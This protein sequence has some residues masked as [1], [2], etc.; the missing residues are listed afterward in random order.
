MS[1]SLDKL[2]QVC[3]R[4]RQLKTPE[5]GRFISIRHRYNQRRWLCF[6]CVPQERRVRRQR[7]PE[8]IRE[9]LESPAA[10]GERHHQIVRIAVALTAKRYSP[11]EIFDLLRPNY[12]A[13][14]CN[15]VPDEEIRDIIEFASGCDFSSDQTMHRAESLRLTPP[16]EAV[17]N[18][19]EFLHGTR[20]TEADLR[21]RCHFQLSG[22]LW[23][24]AVA[25]LALLFQRGE[26]VNLVWGYRVGADGKPQPGIGRTEARGW[27]MTQFYQRR[28]VF[29]GDAGAWIRMNPLDGEGIANRNVVKFRYTLVEFDKVPLDLQLSFLAK[30]DLPIAAIATSG[31]KSLHAW[32]HVGERTQ[33]GYQEKVAAIY[34]RLLPF[35]IDPAN[36]NP[37]RLAR[38]P[39]A[40]RIIGATG[41]GLQRLLFV[42]P[43]PSGQPIL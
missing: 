38:L 39:G 12:D 6:E 40:R 42:T 22:A 37:S 26:Q 28:A 24:H 17:R 32:V 33:Q 18:I 3:C 1:Y 15:P 19:E 5:K 34:R 43:S 7:I 25:L 10:P 2:P 23:D 13:N 16:E 36:K 14:G 20:F 21:P 11:Q 27:W 35:G 30:I 41:D 4:C 8:S 31:G 9:E 29:Q